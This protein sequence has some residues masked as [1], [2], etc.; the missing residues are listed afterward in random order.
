MKVFYVVTGAGPY[1][2][3]VALINLIDEM[4]QRGVEVVVAYSSQGYG[5][6]VD[7]LYDRKIK[8]YEMRGALSLNYP[9]FSFA[10]SP[11]K[12]V[13]ALYRQLFYGN[14]LPYRR[15]CKILRK[16]HPDIVHTNIGTCAYSFFAAKR[17]G[18]PHVWHLREYQT[19]DFGFHFFP[20]RGFFLRLLDKSYS[21]AITEDLYNFHQRNEINCRV[22]YDGVM[23]KDD[24]FYHEEK[25][26]YFLFVGRIDDSK[27]AKDVIDAFTEVGKGNEHVQLWLAGEGRDNYLTMLKNVIATHGLADRVKFL[28]FRSDRYELMQKAKALIVP[29]KC[30]GFGFITVEAMMNGCL[31]IGRN[32]GGTKIIMEKTHGCAIPFMTKDELV[33]AM[34]EVASRSPFY[35]KDRILQAQQVVQQIFSIQKHGEDV[36]DF[37]QEILN[38][39]SLSAQ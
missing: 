10:S 26:D 34:K 11:I 30:E 25:Y 7:W 4:R 36:Y 17:C 23:H 6:M 15:L 37:Y 31:V 2:G 14:F 28:G 13:Y 20:S 27:G 32:T 39:H 38:N 35:Y 21:I 22:I 16:E 18:I 5:A 19:L 33:G 8:N 3:S 12:W 9:F 24:I 29:S 1:G